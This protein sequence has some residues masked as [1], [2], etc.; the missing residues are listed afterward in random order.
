MYVPSYVHVVTCSIYVEVLCMLLC[1]TYVSTVTY[2]K[3]FDVELNE[4]VIINV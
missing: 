3:Y 2:I 1:S 4:E